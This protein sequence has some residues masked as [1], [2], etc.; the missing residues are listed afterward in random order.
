MKF[1]RL[2]QKLYYQ[3]FYLRRAPAVVVK[4]GPDFIELD[5]TV[6]YPE[7]GGQ[8]ADQGCILL[9]DGT[10]IRF[11]WA[12]RM[13][14][15]SSGLPEF[16]DVTLDG[17][18]WHIIDPE[19]AHL[20]ERVQPGSATV[21]EI[22]VERRAR[23]S[24]SHSASHLVYLG[25][26]KVRPDAVANTIGCHIKVDGARFDFA[27][28]SRITAEELQQMTEV[29]NGYVLRNSAISIS[30]HPEFSDARR[31]HAEGLTIPC[32]GIHIDQ[33][34]P[35]GELH[36]KRKAVGAGKERISCTFPQARF[37]TTPYHD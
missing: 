20:I 33:A 3:D 1:H 29:A 5:R 21:V 11:N 17:V 34:G 13:Y 35:I 31:W 6:A 15:H 28:K 36:L 14:G 7:G 16:P 22:D 10:R 23:L 26:G 25:V 2:T 12:K 24:L 18:I 8:E 19:D 37:E 30:S 4:T 32:G 27:V 9:S